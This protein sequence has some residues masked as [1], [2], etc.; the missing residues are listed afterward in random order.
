[1]CFFSYVQRKEANASPKW[2]FYFQPGR[3]RFLPWPWGPPDS[4]WLRVWPKWYIRDVDCS[5]GKRRK[6]SQVCSSDLHAEHVFL[7]PRTASV[8]IDIRKTEGNSSLCVPVQNPGCKWSWLCSGSERSSFNWTPFSPTNCR[9]GR[10]FHVGISAISA[11]GKEPG[12]HMDKWWLGFLISPKLGVWFCKVTLN[13]LGLEKYIELSN[14]WINPK[15]RI[16]K[17]TNK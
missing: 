7:G 6:M 3:L 14:I 11:K 12:H 9:T 17:Q 4:P 5:A 2:D 13:N 15:P 10:C 16:L 8:S 1:M